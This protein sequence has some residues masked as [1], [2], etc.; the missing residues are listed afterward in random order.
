MNDKN[1]PDEFYEYLKSL[2]DDQLAVLVH[3]AVNEDVPSKEAILTEAEE[4][5]KD[6]D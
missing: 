2:T 6:D 1:L 3:T 4:R 5:K